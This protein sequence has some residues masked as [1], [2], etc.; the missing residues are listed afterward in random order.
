MAGERAAV[1]QGLIELQLAGKGGADAVASMREILKQTKEVE[2][3]VGGIKKHFDEAG[4]GADS[5]NKAFAKLGATVAGY[6]A[7]GVVLRFLEDS[8]IGFAKTERQALAVENQIKSLGQAARGAGF[9]DFIRELSDTYGIIDDDLVP[10]FERALGAFKN[11]DTAAEIVTL[12]SKFAA[13]GI[14]EVGSNVDAI[15]RFFQTGMTRGL[16]QFGVN[17]KG[18]EDGV[19]DLTGGL[20]ALKTAAANAGGGFEDAQAKVD[21]ARVLYDTLKDTIGEAQDKLIDFWVHYSQDPIAAAARAR[22]PK[23]PGT[24]G[25]PDKEIYGPQQESPAERQFRE[26]Q[27]RRELAARL[28]KEKELADK[29]RD[30]NEQNDEA[31]L[32]SKIALQQQGSSERLALELE[33]NERMRTAAI[34]NAEAIGADVSKVNRLYDQLADQARQDSDQAI[35]DQADADRKARDQRNAEELKAA[36]EVRH[37]MERTWQEEADHFREMQDKKTQWLVDS[38]KQQTDA[39][40]ESGDRTGAA[41]A[42]IFGKHKNFAIG[43]AIMQTS[44]AIM[45]IWSDPAGGPW[46]VKLAK[47]IAMAAEGAA[48]IQRI[49]SASMS[50]AGSVGTGSGAPASSPQYAASAPASAPQPFTPGGGSQVAPMSSAQF[51]AMTIAARAIGPMTNVFQIRNSFGDKRSMRKLTREIERVQRNNQAVLR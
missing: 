24:P 48:Q 36:K 11:Y 15:A 14:G 31:I 23:L 37:E 20:N 27:G 12:A 33:L 19:L 45:Q 34:R 40:I 32:H 38:S 39:I 25:A 10:A 47:T 28:A 22:L 17:V 30:L 42:E 18:A 46:Y 26:E 49:R 8:Y 41:L 44:E 9:R 43:M 1:I 51:D 13:A 7:S 35:S 2:N 6:F 29:I 5:L 50:G 21:R 3:S 16:V 4:E